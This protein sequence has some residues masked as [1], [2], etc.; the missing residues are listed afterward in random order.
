M[1][2]GNTQTVSLL[3]EWATA[4]SEPP[5]VFTNEG[6]ATTVLANRN[7]PLFVLTNPRKARKKLPVDA[8]PYM[9]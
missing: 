1:G 6:E 3:V 7:R 4:E 5:S 2:K 9:N 8:M